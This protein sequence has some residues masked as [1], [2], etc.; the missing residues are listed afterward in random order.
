MRAVVQRCRAAQ[1]TVGGTLVASIGP[2]LTAFV[3]VGAGDGE[4]DLHYIA[5]KLR[6]LRVF[7]APEAAATGTASP[8]MTVAV[9]EV[10]GEILLVPQFTL[11]GDVRRGLRPDFTAAAMPAVA[12]GL[13]GRL[14]SALRGRGS[15]VSEGVFGAD[16]RVLVDNDGPVTVLLDSRRVF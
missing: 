15:A 6:G 1:V 5:D 7:V 9:G 3:A 4:P 14:A 10:G 8:R 2:G 16:M 11:F 13:L 12:Q